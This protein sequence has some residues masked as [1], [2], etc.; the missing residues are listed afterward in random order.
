VGATPST[1]NFGSTGPRWNEIADFQP[2]IAR[3]ASTVTPSE[4]S[5][6]NA[7][8]KSTTRFSMSLRWSSYVAPKF[9]KGG[10]KHAKRP[11]FIKKCIRLK[12]V[13]YKVYLCGNC[14]RQSCKAFIGLTN[15]NNK[16]FQ[17]TVRVSRRWKRSVHRYASSLRSTRW[18][19]VSSTRLSY[20]MLITLS[21]VSS[22]WLIKQSSLRYFNEICV[23][24]VSAME[25]MSDYK[26]PSFLAVQSSEA[27]H[28]LS[29]CLSV[30]LSVILVS[31]SHLNGS[32]AQRIKILLIMR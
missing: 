24:R 28:L 1:W 19:E 10:L 16:C 30:C 11:I 26:P 27:R 4:K 3:S 8:R 20:N 22:D 18:F 9:P 21:N 2:I 5:S 31:H 17:V 12:K 23:C 14:Q 15:R 32:A 13:C 7:N 6:I 29:E 25:M